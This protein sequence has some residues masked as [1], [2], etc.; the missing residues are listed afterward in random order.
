MDFYGF[1]WV[2]IYYIFPSPFH[3]QKA[4]AIHPESSSGSPCW[5]PVQR[6][7]DKCSYST[8]SNVTFDARVHKPLEY[9]TQEAK[10]A[11][12]FS[13]AHRKKMDAEWTKNPSTAKLYR[14]RW[15]FFKCPRMDELQCVAEAH[16]GYV[17]QESVQL[18][19]KNIS[20][21]CDSALR[22]LMGPP[23]TPVNCKSYESYECLRSHW[24]DSPSWPEAKPHRTN[25][26]ERSQGKK[27]CRC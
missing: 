23:P 1:Q 8:N 9:N 10:F 7:V 12:M 2:S 25:S 20:D 26:T 18:L 6:R 14:D 24:T 5:R 13:V 22:R 16:R 15:R 21:L 11:S 17:W 27:N 19:R 3:W 4:P